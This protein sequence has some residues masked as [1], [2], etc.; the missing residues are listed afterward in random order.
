MSLHY[1]QDLHRSRAEREPRETSTRP[2]RILPARISLGSAPVQT[3]ARKNSIAKAGRL[4]H[5]LTPLRPRMQTKR[6]EF[7]LWI[8]GFA[9]GLIILLGWITEITRVPHFLFAEPAEIVWAR[10]LLKTAVILCV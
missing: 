9:F 3:S 10:P 4:H 2:P 6:R 5:F 7:I 8:E 1:V